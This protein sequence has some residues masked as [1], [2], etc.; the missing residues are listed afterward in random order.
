MPDVAIFEQQQQHS[1]PGMRCKFGAAHD[2]LTEQQQ[3][4]LVHVMFERDDITSSAIG[5]VLA[6]QAWHGRL[7]SHS[8]VTRHRSR[9]CF[10]CT[11]RG[12]L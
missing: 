12:R 1:N 11:T 3:Q 9:Q 10:E 7:W 2:K 4:Q 8:T 5:R 6:D